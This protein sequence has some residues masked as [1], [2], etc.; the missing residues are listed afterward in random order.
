MTNRLDVWTPEGVK[1][2]AC[3]DPS[4]AARLMELA[5]EDIEWAIEEYGRCDAPGFIAV[6]CGQDQP[7]GDWEA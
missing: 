6:P 2:R 5:P 7:K 3:V 4:D 1:V